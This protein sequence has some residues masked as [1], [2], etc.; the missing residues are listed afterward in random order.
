MIILLGVGE[1]GK[2]DLQLLLILLL[3]LLLE[4]VVQLEYV[5]HVVVVEVGHVERPVL[6]VLD[7]GGRR[8]LGEGRVQGILEEDGLVVELI[9]GGRG[10]GR[11]GSVSA[12]HFTLGRRGVL[13]SGPI[14][15]SSYES[16][17]GRLHVRSADPGRSSISPS[18]MD[19]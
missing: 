15:S 1:G 19:G 12:P 13:L 5:R 10:G 18:P 14:V 3:L 11:V 4:L 9:G 17:S 7:G 8:V 16:D 2:A 6:V